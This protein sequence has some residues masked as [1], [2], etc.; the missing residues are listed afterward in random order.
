VNA[1]VRRRVPTI[2]RSIRIA[3]KTAS[4]HW[5]DINMKNLGIFAS[6]ILAMLLLIINI[7]A[8]GQDKEEKGKSEEIG[9]FEIVTHIVTVQVQVY[10]QNGASVMNLARDDFK[11]YEDGVEQVLLFFMTEETDIAYI[12]LVMNH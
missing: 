9:C 3:D 8:V 11:V 2:S 10:D 12:Q 6:L 1:A 7:S 5:G 4:I